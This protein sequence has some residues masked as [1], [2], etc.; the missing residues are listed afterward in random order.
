MLN[1]IKQLFGIC[2]HEYEKT[3]LAGFRVVDGSYQSL[4]KSAKKVEKSKR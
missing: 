2:E 4:L 3:T 1:K